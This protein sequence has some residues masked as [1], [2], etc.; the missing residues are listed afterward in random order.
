[1]EFYENRDTRKYGVYED[2]TLQKDLV[3]VFGWLF[4]G[5]LISA[6][7]AYSVAN[8]FVASLSRGT[9]FLSAI[10]ELVLV[11]YLSARINKISYTSAKL[12]FI[13]YSAVN[14]FS[15]SSIFLVYNIGSLVTAFSLSAVFFGFM[16]LYGLIT[17]KDLSRFS[18]IFFV[19]MISLLVLSIVNVFLRNPAFDSFLAY[20]GVALFVGIT[21]YDIQRIKYM[22]Q[23]DS[24]AMN[25]KIAIYGALMLYLDF[26]NL[27]INVLTI[28]GKKDD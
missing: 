10:L 14:G 3:K 15:L 6:A 12:A 11:V 9:V 24:G 26:I 16:A 28:L 18:T 17:K 19:G 7:T 23:M 4:V 8:F 27:F 5:L 2:D 21:A 1:M 20:M 22:F 13:A 25:G